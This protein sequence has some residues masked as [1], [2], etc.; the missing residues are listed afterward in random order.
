MKLTNMIFLVS[1]SLAFSVNAYATTYAGQDCVG[2]A[3]KSL[4]YFSSY[5][6]NT[7]NKSMSIVCP[8]VRHKDGGTRSV[9]PVIYFV[10]DGKKKICFLTIIT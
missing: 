4:K 10:N 1:A 8:V 2:K 3:G 6:K 9:N 7:S 5:A